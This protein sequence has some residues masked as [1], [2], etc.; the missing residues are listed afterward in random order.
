M[1]KFIKSFD[2][3]VVNM[4]ADLMVLCIASAYFME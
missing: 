3:A 1:S 4:D 2:K